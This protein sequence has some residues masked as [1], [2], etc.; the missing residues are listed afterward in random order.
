[1]LLVLVLLITESLVGASGRTA[2]AAPS[3]APGGR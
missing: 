3:R 2:Q 1:L